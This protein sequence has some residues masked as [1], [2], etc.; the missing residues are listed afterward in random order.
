MAE[1]IV[2]QLEAI[3]VQKHQGE[4]STGI[5]LQRLQGLPEAFLQPGPVRQLGQGI[6]VGHLFELGI[7]A[8][9]T[10]ESATAPYLRAAGSGPKP[11]S[12]LPE[13]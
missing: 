6:V 4:L 10:A 11:S 5:L 13:W 1:G 7:G 9:P 12:L 3:A 2:H 8:P